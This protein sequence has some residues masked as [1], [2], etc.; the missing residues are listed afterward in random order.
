[1]NKYLPSKKFMA[2]FALIV[3]FGGGLFF[4]SRY[5]KKV[6]TKNQEAMKIKLGEFVDRDTDSDGVKDWEEALWGTDPLKGDTNDDGISDKDDID[7][8]KFALNQQNTG[9][10]I[11]EGN[12][13]DVFSKELFT[14][15]ISLKETGAL[16]PETISDLAQ[17]LGSNVST[18][19]EL[20]VMYTSTSIEIVSGVRAPVSLSEINVVNN[21]FEKTSVSFPSLI[22]PPVF[23]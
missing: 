16:T 2:I 5:Q 20:P 17:K 4:L 9:G 18:K 23:C 8:K 12:E 13:T 19:K 1:M 3:L 6:V 22:S 21:S 14:T 11:S 15:L 7:K 10:D